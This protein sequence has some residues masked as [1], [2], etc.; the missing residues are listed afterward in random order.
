M[1]LSLI[2]LS[3]QIQTSS[4]TPYKGNTYQIVIVKIDAEAVSKFMLI[5]N[6]QKIPH[7]AFLSSLKKDSSFFFKEEQAKNNSRIR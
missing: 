6:D 3:A 4:N 7:Q 1:S 5:E 2:Q